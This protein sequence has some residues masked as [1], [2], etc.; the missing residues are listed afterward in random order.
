MK[1]LDSLP[2][3]TWVYNDTGFPLGKIAIHL[4][5][6]GN[7]APVPFRMIDDGK[8]GKWRGIRLYRTRQE[9]LKAKATA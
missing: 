5:M 4:A 6:N 9:Q 3:G 1:D 8:P 2:I 7:S